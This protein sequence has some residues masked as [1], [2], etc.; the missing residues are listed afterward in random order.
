VSV[1]LYDGML[2]A[3]AAADAI[4]A[5]R[6]D[7][8]SLGSYQRLW[9]S[10]PF[11]KAWRAGLVLKREMRRYLLDG[12]LESVFSKF[13]SEVIT[14]RRGMV[15]KVVDKGVAFKEATV[16]HRLITTLFDQVL[17]YGM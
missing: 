16:M 6:F 1:A 7:A 3:A 4:E 8:R 17:D 10:G 11:H 15:G 13:D 2:A 12:R 5:G 9:D 14:G